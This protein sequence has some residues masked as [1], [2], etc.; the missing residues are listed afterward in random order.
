MIARILALV[1]VVKKW[2]KK[3]HLESRLSLVS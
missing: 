1:S 2:A 3:G